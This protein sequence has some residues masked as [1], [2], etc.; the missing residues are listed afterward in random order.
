MGRVNRLLERRALRRA[1][2]QALLTALGTSAD[3]AGGP[4]DQGF[5]YSD[6]ERGRSLPVEGPTRAYD[7]DPDTS[8]IP[9]LHVGGSAL[10]H[11]TPPWEQQ[12]PVDDP[13]ESADVNDLVSDRSGRPASH[14]DVDA[15]G[16]S[17]L[18]IAEPGRPDWWDERA[19]D[20]AAPP[21]AVSSPAARARPFAETAYVRPELD[22]AVANFRD[23]RWYR[24][25]SGA[26]VLA[27][28]LVVAVV[29]GGWLVVRS[30]STT[31]E[32]SPTTPP[33]SASPAPRPAAPT[34]ASAAEPKAK[35]PPPP[36]LPPPPPPPPPAGST[37]SP[38][39]RQYQPRYSEPTPAQ[40]PR[41][42]VTRAPM[43]VAPVPKPVPG[44]DSNTPGDAPGE[45]PRRRGCFGF[46]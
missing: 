25:K 24:T 33:P 46:C 28:A 16:L 32:E 26:A 7:H 27:A 35:P 29:L 31:A 13:A 45:K 4:P 3:P 39:Q 41:V 12:R 8:P 38:P 19:D 10:P 14:D 30:P 6:A 5:T 18:P 1:A 9:V 15:P 17:A 40:K 36:P 2:D 43:S 22:F 34:A 37:Y 23:A 44:S 20:A 42:D 21:V 11:S